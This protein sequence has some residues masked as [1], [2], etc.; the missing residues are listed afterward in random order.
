MQTATVSSEIKPNI[1]TLESPS[2]PKELIY[3]IIDGKPIYYKGYKAYLR[4]EKT[5]DDIIGTGRLQ[6]RILNAIQRHL[7]L[8]YHDD[9]KF[10]SNEVGIHVSISVNFSCDLVAFDK[11]VLA[12]SEDDNHYYNFPP[13]FVIEVDTNSDIEDGNF[14]EYFFA[15][16]KNSLILALRK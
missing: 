14:I 2:I 6:T 5:L 15:K 11:T 1:R 4:K 3:E 12:A 16:S 10:L 7:I 9:Y 8:N 13:K